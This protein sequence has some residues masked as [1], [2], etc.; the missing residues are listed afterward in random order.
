MIKRSAQRKRASPFNLLELS[1][2]R[3]S[4]INPSN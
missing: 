1:K 4:S 3:K 2:D